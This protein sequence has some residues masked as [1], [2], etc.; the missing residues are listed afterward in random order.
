M[1]IGVEGVTGGW[2]AGSKVFKVF[3][4]SKCFPD[5]FLVFGVGNTLKN[6]PQVFPEGKTS[7]YQA[8]A[9][10]W[11]ALGHELNIFHIFAFGDL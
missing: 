5:I 8:S 11:R 10:T 2:L 1:G 7:P 6:N 4:L 3:E 9:T